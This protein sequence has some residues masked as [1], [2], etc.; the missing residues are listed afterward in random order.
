MTTIITRLYADQAAA[1]AVASTLLQ[2]GQDEDTIEFITRDSVGGPEAAMK[3]ARVPAASAVVYARAMS[4]HEAL[5]VVAAPFNPMGAAREAIQVVN[6]SPAI[7]VGLADEDVYIR[8]TPA[9]EKSGN[10]LT[11]HPLIMSNPH[12]R[13]SHSHI[14]GSNPIMASKPRTSAIRG[15]AYMS[16]F[17]WPMKLVSAPK[18]KTSAIRGGF[19]FSSMFGLPTVIRSWGPRED[20]PTIL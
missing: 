20:F 11:S 16:R 17:F 12:S 13:P 18:E 15:G 8:E 5:L 4:G 2:K 3:A 1:R 7:N 14:L 9:V 6:K 19:L 10:V